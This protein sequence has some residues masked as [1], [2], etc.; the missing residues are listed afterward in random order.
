MIDLNLA[1]LHC[2]INIKWPLPIVL[3]QHLLYLHVYIHNSYLCIANSKMLILYILIFDDL[4]AHLRPINNT[5]PTEASTIRQKIKALTTFAESIHLQWICSLQFTWLHFPLDLQKRL[6]NRGISVMSV[7]YSSIGQKKHVLDNKIGIYICFGGYFTE[8][9]AE[10]I[11]EVDI[12][13]GKILWWH[14]E[15][16]SFH[17]TTFHLKGKWKLDAQHNARTSCGRFETSFYLI[18]AKILLSFIRLSLFT[19]VQ[20]IWGNCNKLFLS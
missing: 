7:I 19:F 12:Q 16:D 18:S 15:G 17:F 3:S 5:A 8:R 2:K 1:W 4:R 6:C 13:R 14:L 10:L 9:V 20:N 11:I